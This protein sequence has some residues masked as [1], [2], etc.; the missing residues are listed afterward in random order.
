[1]MKTIIAPG[2]LLIDFFSKDAKIYERKMGGA[3]ANVCVGISR[4]GG[5][6]MFL[7][8]VGEDQFGAF[9]HDRLETEGVDVRGLT[10]I[11]GMSTTLAFVSNDAYGERQFSFN[12][13]ADAAWRYDDLESILPQKAI[14][15]LG[16]ATALLGDTLLAS[17]EALLV[18]AKAKGWPVI[19]DPNYREDLYK[20]KQETFIADAIALMKQADLV[21]VSDDEL[22][23]LTAC[24]CVEDGVVKLQEL[25]I[26][27]VLVTLGVEGVFYKAQT[28]ETK[29]DAI[30]V[31][32]LDTTGAGDA[33]I[34]AVLLELSKT[35]DV[36]AFL[37]NQEGMTQVFRRAAIVAGLTCT[38][39]GAV[40][41][42]PTL[43]D[44]ETY[45][46]E[47]HEK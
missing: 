28:Y 3:P 25:G 13:G 37:E 2:E 29:A 17:I 1:M 31:K 35:E 6:S 21:K 46:R 5:Q 44:L 7:G 43:K 11:Q 20:N 45:E 8:S 23:L 47:N 4:L 40:A 9:L 36:V 14:L 12:R 41:A 32:V 22:K 15:H 38:D 19:V 26:K 30:D 34:A 18:Y 33:F 27:R 24:E 39:Y 42:L 16:S 10:R